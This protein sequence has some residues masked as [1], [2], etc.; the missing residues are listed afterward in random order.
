M[1]EERADGPVVI[2]KYAN[3]RLYNTQTS[4]YVTLDH[5]AQMV[6]A[7]TE[8]EVHDARSGEDITRSVLTQIIFEEEAKGQNLLPIQFLRRL[9][10]FYG[11]SLQA[12]VPGYLDMSM[13]S[14]TKNQEAMR[15]KVA[16]AF[17][18]G[19]QAF[20]N[21][22]RQ[23]FAMY[24]RAMKMFTP[25]VPGARGAEDDKPE[26]K[27]KQSEDI[28]ELKSEIEAMRKQLAELARERK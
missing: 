12:F 2:K 10:R 23:N 18:G 28:G 20:E 14:L 27:A 11:D 24:E 7:G 6:K 13:E 4:S 25:F 8:F 1:T 9:I 21:L 16:E 3:R 15:S 5:L 17:G 22:T 26:P 19:S